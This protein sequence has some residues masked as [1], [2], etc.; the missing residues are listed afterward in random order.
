MS[1]FLSGGS[2]I[3]VRDLTL[4]ALQ[5]LGDT[6]ILCHGVALSPGKPLILARCGQT[7]VWGLPGQV[8][9][10]QVVIH[11]LG[12]PFLRHLAGHSLMAQLLGQET[13][14]TDTRSSKHSAF[15]PSHIVAQHSLP[16]RT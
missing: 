13:P 9:S 2:S 8:A 10:A 1:S 4:E 14:D 15:A 12:I 6:E 11:I 5:S 7:L 16:P 3:G